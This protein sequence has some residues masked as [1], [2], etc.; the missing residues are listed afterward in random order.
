MKIKADAKNKVAFNNKVDFCVGTGRMGLALTQEYYDELKFTQEHIGFSFIRGHGL[1]TDDMAIFQCFD[2]DGVRRIEY[3]YTYL[4]RVLDMYQSVGI[5]P[6]FELGFMPK[7]MA[8]GE[9][10]IFYWKGNTTPPKDY[11]EWADMI[12]AM[13]RHC[14]DRYGEQVYDWPIEVWNEPNLPGFWKGADM[15]EYFKLFEVSYKAVKK[16]SKRFKVGGPAVCGIR[17][18]FWIRSFLDFCLKRKLKPDFVTRHHYTT[19]MPERAGHYGYQILSLPEFGFANLKT[20]RDAIDSYPE[21]KGLPIHITEFNTSYIPNNPIHDTNI[22]AAYLA[23]QLSRLGDV[24]ESYSY[25]TFGDVFEEQGVPFSQ[26]HGGFG[27]VAHHCIP[28]PTFWSFAFFKKLKNFSEKCIYKDDGAVIVADG[29]GGFAGIAWNLSDKD[30]VVDI[31][32][33]GKAAKGDKYTLITETV[34]E[35]VC[36]PLKIWHDLGEPR[37]PSDAEVAVIKSGSMPLVESETIEAAAGGKL[38]LKFTLNRFGVKYF[39]VKPLAFEGDTG[40]DYKKIEDVSLTDLRNPKKAIARK[41]EED[42][43]A[44]EAMK[45]FAEMAKKGIKPPFPVAPVAP[46]EVKKPEAKP[47]KKPVAKKAAATVKKAVE[48]AKKAATKKTA[49]KKTVKNK[50]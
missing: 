16:V 38:A 30:S 12:S 19:E 40:Y 23:Q 10:T 1:F 14:I 27:L 3:N 8:S 36:N 24:N 48:A 42:A 43:K 15:Q 35:K 5:A 9:Q 2:Y 47:E 13:L 17:D 39:T 20:S 44:K 7:K 34:D 41:A 46:A 45:K 11:K 37:Y 22:N 18:E 25:W 31:E 32:L 28:K 6:F 49:A 29:K 21:F 4:D 50:K 26:F 33:T